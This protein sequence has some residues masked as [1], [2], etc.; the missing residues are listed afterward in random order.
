MTQTGGPIAADVTVQGPSAAGAIR[1]VLVAD[2]SAE[3]VAR[4][5]EALAGLDVDAVATPP[6][7]FERLTGAAFDL[8]LLDPALGEDDDGAL[9][10]VHRARTVAPDTV[11]VIWSVKPTVEFTVRAMRSGALDVLHKEAAIPEIR[12]VVDRAIQ[13]GALARE[14]RRLR[15]EVERA[16]GLGEVIGESALMRQLLQMIERVAA[17]DATVLIVGESGTGKELLARTIHRIGPR[18]EGPFVAFDCSALAPSLLEAE[19]F[20]HEKGAFTGAM[21]ARRGLFREASGGTI[22]LDEIGDI[23]AS[24]QNKLL[25]VLQEREIKP[26]G[27]DRPVQI[28]VRVVAATNKDLKALVARGQF[29]EDL[30]W[31]L[32]VVPIQVPPL[33]ERKED[34]PLL[35]AHIL[36]R[37]RGAAKSFAGNE[38]RYPTQITAK[39]LSR[40]MSYRWPG[41]IR[42]LEN[43]LSRAAILCDGEMIRS[44]DLAMIGLDAGKPGGASS[45]DEVDRVDVPPID[46]ERLGD[47]ES[48][49]DVTERAVRAV[50][51]A[52]IAAALKRDRNPAA[53]A[54]R[55]GISRASIYTK[56]KTY[57][58]DSDGEA[59]E[60]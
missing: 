46:L 49:K 51:R 31:R 26:V 30:Y 22:F 11:V 20:G 38:A 59:A 5:R 16:R 33:R 32:A 57:G 17:S 45:D 7:A 53:A 60:S 25:R 27:G 18:A 52:A 39:A 56:M 42:E 54:K 58:L 14:V 37:R 4:A 8:L 13:H 19:L 3:G 36:A 50:E 43:V 9:A 35:A 48:L 55:L 12:S 10:L 23:D 40:L 15:G 44:H 2:A 21:R 28:D 41:N 34:I 1:H 29:R 47:G 24:V 6:A